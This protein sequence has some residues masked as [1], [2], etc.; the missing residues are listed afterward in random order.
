MLSTAV[1][2]TEP[3]DPQDAG[4]RHASLPEKFWLM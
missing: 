2:A 4:Q 1:T 3:D